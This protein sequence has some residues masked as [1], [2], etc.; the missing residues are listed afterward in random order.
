VKETKAAVSAEGVLA[1]QSSFQVLGQVAMSGLM[2]DPGVGQVL[3]ELGK[4]VDT[5]KLEAIMKPAP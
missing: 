1:I 5:N 2:S 3:A 4:F